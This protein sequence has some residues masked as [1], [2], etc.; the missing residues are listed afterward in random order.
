MT[1]IRHDLEVFHRGDEAFVLFREVPLVGKREGVHGLLE[2]RF[3][4][5]RGRFAFGMKMPF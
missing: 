4:K 1:G 3:S 5:L 2:N